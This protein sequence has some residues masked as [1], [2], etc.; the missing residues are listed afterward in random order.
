[1]QS[2]R[3]CV[4][5]HGEPGAAPILPGVRTSENC[6]VR[7]LSMET[8]STRHPSFTQLDPY[9]FWIPGRT[10]R[11]PPKT[12]MEITQDWTLGQ[13]IPDPSHV[14]LTDFS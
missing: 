9:A 7:N 14:Y 2:P 8:S 6:Q 10:S 13:G 3:G 4:L 5:G 12:V 11:R 1:M